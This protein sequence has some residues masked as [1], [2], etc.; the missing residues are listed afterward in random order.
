[1]AKAQ[2]APADHAMAHILGQASRRRLLVTALRLC[3]AFSRQ[4]P[5]LSRTCRSAAGSLSATSMGSG[6]RAAGFQSAP[7][8]RPARRSHR[9]MMTGTSSSPARRAARQRRSPAMIMYPG[10]TFWAA[11]QWLQKP[12]LG[13]AVGQ[14]VQR[15]VVKPLAGCSGS[16]SISRSGSVELDASLPVS[17]DRS[18]KQAVQPRQARPSFFGHRRPHIVR[19]FQKFPRQFHVRLAA[20]AVRLIEVDQPPKLGPRSAHGA[21]NDAR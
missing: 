17:S 3:P 11:P 8:R 15:V 10:P 16:G 2:L 19:D 20:L 21:R 9:L 12:V 18:G 5:A 1:M 6:P 13:D 4:I 14:L 7:A